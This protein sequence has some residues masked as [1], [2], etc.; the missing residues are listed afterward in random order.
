[1]ELLYMLR[2]EGRNP[3]VRRRTSRWRS[4]TL[5]RKE[6]EN[7]ESQPGNIDAWTPPDVPDSFA[8]FPGSFKTPPARPVTAPSLSAFSRSGDLPTQL[9]VAFL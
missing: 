7:G 1:M 3:D 6:R 9:C 5:G 8:S 4:A 2:V